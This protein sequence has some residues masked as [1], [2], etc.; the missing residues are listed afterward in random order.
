MMYRDTI[1]TPFCLL[2]LDY[3]EDA[4]HEV[5]YVQQRDVTPEQYLPLRKLIH[6]QVE[7]YLKH[8]LREFDLPLALSGTEFQQRVW[9]AL[10]A[11][12]MAEVLS[13]GEMAQQLGSA[14][15]AVGQA[16]RRNPC[17]LI[18]PCHRVIAAGRTL[19]GFHGQTEGEFLRIKQRLLAHEGVEIKP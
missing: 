15:R 17:P 1:A 5:S 13:Y 9:H 7:A 10:Q 6:Q 18:V 11:I 2:Q 16:C 19:G 14:A 8:R 3:S 4:I 12:P